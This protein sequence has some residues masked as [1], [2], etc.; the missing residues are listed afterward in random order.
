M[1]SKL[2]EFVFILTSDLN[3]SFMHVVSSDIY[4][5]I[6]TVSVQNVSGIACKHNL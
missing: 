1:K 2:L 3:D 5:D 6:S 4:C